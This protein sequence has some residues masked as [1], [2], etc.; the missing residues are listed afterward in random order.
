M[1]PE[2][3]QIGKRVRVRKDHRKAEMRSRE[4]IIANRWGN[5][6][7]PALDVLH[8]EGDLQLFWYY[9]LELAD[10]DRGSRRQTEPPRGSRRDLSPARSSLRGR[11]AFEV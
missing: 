3:A 4:G 9:E 7:Y 11:D 8:Y 10:D 5:P 2:E 1:R 6:T